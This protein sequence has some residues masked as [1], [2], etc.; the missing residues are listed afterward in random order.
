MTLSHSHPLQVVEAAIEVADIAWT[1]IE[2]HKKHSNSSPPSDSS[3]SR[4]VAAIEAC[5][6]LEKLLAE[7]RCENRRLDAA[8]RECRRSIREA[9]L[10]TIPSDCP[11]DVSAT[12]TC[13][14]AYIHVCL[15]T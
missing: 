1:A 7:E 15:H 5:L 11:S 14:F 9:K 13:M 6:M 12:Y 8:L 4:D 2:K 3:S 10:A